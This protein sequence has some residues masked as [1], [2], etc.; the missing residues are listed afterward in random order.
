M[1]MVKSCL[2]SLGGQDLASRFSAET[3]TCRRP[4]MEAM[5]EIRKT[6]QDMNANLSWATP[7]RIE[8]DSGRTKLWQLQSMR[9]S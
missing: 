9:S 7:V 4:V 6:A 5:K 1:R 3:G 8:G 2:W